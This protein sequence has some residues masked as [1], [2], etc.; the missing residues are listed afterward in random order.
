[1]AQRVLLA[2]K[3][4]DST[5]GLNSKFANIVS[6]GP[7]DGLIVQAT[8]TPS[9]FVT[10]TAGNAL[11]IEGVKIEESVS[12]NAIVE[13]TPGHPSRRRKDIIFLYHKY[14]AAMTEPQ[15]NP[16]TYGIVTGTVSPDNVTE[17]EA[18]YDQLTPYHI[19][20]AELHVPAGANF[21]VSDMI[22]NLERTH[23]TKRLHDYMAEAMYYAW[24]NFAYHGWEVTQASLTN[25]VVSPGKGLLYGKVNV[26]DDETIVTGL[27]FQHY[28][29][30]PNDPSTGAPYE[31]GSN[32]TLLE[33]PDF[34]SRIAIEITTTTHAVGGNIYV[35]GRDE[36]GTQVLDLIIPVSQPA[37]KIETYY[38]EG[39]FAEI[40]LE[41]IDA[42]ELVI[43]GVKTFISIKDMPV[44][45]I[46]AAG[47]PIGRPIFR[48]ELNPAYKPKHNELIIA[49]VH[50]DVEKILDVDPIGISPLSDWVD[51]LGPCDGVRKI[52]YATGTPVPDTHTLWYDGSRLFEDLSENYKD[53]H[54]KGYKLNGREI[55]LG[56]AVPAPDPNTVL[57]FAYRRLT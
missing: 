48:N 10:I 33:Q 42:H 26:S 49:K 3:S 54:G 31:V 23:T 2:H 21:I 52:F 13:I 12:L 55:A 46:I 5:R 30:P 56:S 25:V 44:S 28:I 39:Y 4:T 11:T 29:R 32:L 27:R 14:V 36:L 24:G 15:G 41:G 19:P 50:T 6:E 40:F 22:F 45:Y 16:A 7:Y 9:L 8:D 53:T 38:S 57:R 37:N 43:P 47:T 17:P 1:M 35:S 51:V 18:P 20:L 34:P